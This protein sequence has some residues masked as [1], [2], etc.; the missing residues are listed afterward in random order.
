MLI[1][2][3]S[4]LH[5]ES[6]KWHL[7]K[8]KLFTLS[9]KE[10]TFCN[11]WFLF[12]FTFILHLSLS[13]LEKIRPIIAS[14]TENSQTSYCT[15]PSDSEISS[16]FSPISWEHHILHSS[17][18]PCNLE[19]CAPSCCGCS[20]LIL[21]SVIVA[22]SLGFLRAISLHM[23]RLITCITISQGDECVLTIC[24]E[25]SYQVWAGLAVA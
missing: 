11:R 19:Q 16:S 24:I 7:E 15:S 4:L 12:N 8:S 20:S 13:L 6:R 9:C 3:I 5:L 14:S 23:S 18:V 1:Q 2:K 21:S 17:W 10:Q 22:W 25:Y